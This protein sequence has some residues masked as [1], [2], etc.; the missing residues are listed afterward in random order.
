[1]TTYPVFLE[2]ARRRQKIRR[3][4]SQLYA[5]PVANLNNSGL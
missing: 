3:V 5:Q 1:M 4:L 2:I